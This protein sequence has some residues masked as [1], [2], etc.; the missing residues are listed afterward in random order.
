MRFVVTGEW[1]RNHFLRVIVLCFLGYTFILWV[2]NAAM[3]FA[4]MNLTPA[5]VVEYYLG[6]EDKYLQPRSLQGLLEVLHFHS[7]AMGMLLMTLTHLLLFVPLANRVKAWGIGLAFASGI[8]GE[9]AGWGVRFVHP[10]FAY[11]KIAS[12]LTLEGV[13]L[14]LMFLVTRALLTGAPSAYGRRGEAPPRP[15]T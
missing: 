4:K 9:L 1:T 3:F 13:L 6:N 8:G 14:W 12:F 10:L 11:V 2:T 7:F 5:S 15:L